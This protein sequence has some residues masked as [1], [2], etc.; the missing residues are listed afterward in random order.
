LATALSLQS[1]ASPQDGG[2]IERA[3]QE[4]LA[5]EVA[6]ARKLP[7][8]GSLQV[9]QARAP[10]LRD[11]GQDAALVFIRNVDLRF[12]G[13]IGFQVEQLSMRFTPT[14]A[15]EPVVLDDPSSFTITPVA[16]SVRLDAR[17]MTSLFNEFLFKNNGVPLRN[18]RLVPRDGAISIFAEMRRKAWV[19]IELSGTLRL[20]DPQTIVFSPSK[21]VVAGDDASR[22]LT[23]AGIELSDLLNVRT[24]AVELAGS[25]VVM[26]VPRMFPKPV[27][28]TAVSSIALTRDGL[29]LHFGGTAAP[30]MAVPA[31]EPGTY[32]RFLGGDVKFLRTM[33]MNTDISLVPAQA[34]K[35]FVFD[36][37]RYRE[38]VAAGYLQFEQSGAIRVAMPSYATLTAAKGA[39]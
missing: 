16:G 39:K 5:G 26:H 2:A 14:V 8:V 27:L 34:N 11:S 23:R 9:R 19:P 28:N 36:L 20:R 31:G 21:V 4:Q 24:P 6:T 12:V 10:G 15:G 18:F 17:A 7:V 25:E 35:P 1:C 33:P 38:Q 29:S 37:Y 3:K 13:D 22:L 32:I 30:Q